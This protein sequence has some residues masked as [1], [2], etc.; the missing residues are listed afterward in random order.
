M[1]HKNKLIVSSIGLS[2]MLGGCLDMNSSGVD[3]ENDKQQETQDEQLAKETYVSV[4]DYTGEGYELDNGEKTDKIAE[5]NREEIDKAVKAF[6]RDSYKTEVV[7]HNVVG[8]ADG[9]TVFVESVGEPHFYTYA[10][11][12]IDVERG[13]VLTD[14]V[15]SQ[16]GQVEN[17]IKTGIFAMIFDAEIA[18][19]DQYIEGVVNEYPVVGFTNEALENVRAGGYSTPYY[20]LNTMGDSLDSLFDLYIKNP[21]LSREEWKKKFDKNNYPADGIIT[22]VYLYM[23]EEGVEPD[24]EVF[25]KIVSDIENMDG[26]AKGTYSVFL[27]D[28]LVDKSSSRGVKDNSLERSFPDDIIKE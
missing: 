4:Q 24:K 15:W 17:S 26:L 25:N 28:N 10:I 18:T 9:A 8:A 14:K 21:E 6:F 5:E 22:T 27:N 19:L 12:P 13:V 3:K 23:E 2:L 20:Y 11:I 7:V 1:K 16:E